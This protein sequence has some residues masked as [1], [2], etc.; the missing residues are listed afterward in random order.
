MPSVDA[1]FTFRLLAEDDF[2]KLSIKFKRI[3]LYQIRNKDLKKE[4][5]KILDELNKINKERNN[6]AHSVF[7]TIG[8]EE[9][10][11]IKLKPD[12]QLAP[13]VFEKTK[14]KLEDIEK[15]VTK[16]IKAK[17]T[18]SDLNKRIASFNRLSI[19]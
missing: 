19:K 11:R 15:L 6:F 5:D 10:N 12:I 9:I 13:S 16:I 1:N 8:E 18:L 3:F 14:L 4:F 17:E 2:H 7:I